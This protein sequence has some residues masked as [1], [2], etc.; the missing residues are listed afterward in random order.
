MILVTFGTIKVVF[1]RLAEA[2]V[3]LAETFPKEKI[4]V[5]SGHTKIKQ[6]RKNLI[7]KS[8]MSK[9]AL[10]SLYKKSRLVIAHAGEGSVIRAMMMG[11]MSSAI[12]VPRDFRYGEHVDDQQMKIGQALEAGGLGRVVDD[13]S[14][15]IGVVKS[16]EVDVGVSFGKVGRSKRL[17]RL[18]MSLDKYCKQLT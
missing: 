11:K 16:I 7:V 12:Y 3:E 4:L 13:P 15:L 10:E 5:Q 2:V 18:V 1:E 17:N 6:K 9:S 14:D 8:F